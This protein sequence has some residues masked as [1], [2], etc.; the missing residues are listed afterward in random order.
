[1][2]VENI[3]FTSQYICYIL[4]VAQ[5]FSLAHPGLTRQMSAA[6]RCRVDAGDSAFLTDRTEKKQYLVELH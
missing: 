2:A 6:S 5:L 4:T 3:C 1:M